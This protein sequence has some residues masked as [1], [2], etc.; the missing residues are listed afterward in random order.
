MNQRQTCSS[1]CARLAGIQIPCP[2]L[3]ALRTR[4]YRSG[5]VVWRKPR[6]EFEPEEDSLCS[7]SRDSNPGVVSHAPRI[8]RRCNSA[9]NSSREKPRPEFES[10]VSSLPR[11][12]FT[13]KL[14]RHALVC[15][16]QLSLGVSI[17]TDDE[18]VSGRRRPDCRDPP[19]GRRCRRSTAALRLGA[20][21]L[22]GRH[23]PRA[24]PL[25][26]RDRRR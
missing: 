17:P 24:A 3:H 4:R 15:I 6:P 5:Q 14:P 23:R 21:R 7:S 9:Q 16:R 1:R 8:A 10:G 25:W 20:R 22:P 12:R 13:A 2:A 11:T 19:A 18:V 26:A